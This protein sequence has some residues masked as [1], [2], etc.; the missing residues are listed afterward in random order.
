MIT[1]TG[2]AF[3]FEDTGIK[4]DVELQNGDWKKSRK[5]GKEV[6]KKGNEMMLIEKYK[7]MPFQSQTFSKQ[8]TECSM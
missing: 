2:H 5:K 8:A 4:L 3:R 7:E 6:L 1:E